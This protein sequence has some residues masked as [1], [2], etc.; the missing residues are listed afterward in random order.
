V[1]VGDPLLVATIIRVS[2]RRR[3]VLFNVY[4]DSPIV[5]T[6]RRK[7]LEV[8]DARFDDDPFWEDLVRVTVARHPNLLLLSPLSVTSTGGVKLV[9]LVA[10][11]STVSW[12][13]STACSGKTLFVMGVEELIEVVM[14]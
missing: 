1:F 4:A 14:V 7:D 9:D 8:L 3:D 5:L 2:L 10:G 11:A 6:L 13:G 12:R